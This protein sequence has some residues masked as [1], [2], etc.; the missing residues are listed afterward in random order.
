MELFETLQIVTSQ[1]NHMISNMAQ[2]LENDR[3]FTDDPA[4][5]AKMKDWV[6]AWLHAQEVITP[7][8][9]KPRT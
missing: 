2:M 4:W 7:G 3:R 6:R 5:D 9:S 1:A 8:I